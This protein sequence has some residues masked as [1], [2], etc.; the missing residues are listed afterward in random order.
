MFLCPCR[1]QVPLTLQEYLA[2]SKPRLDSQSSLADREND[3]GYEY[4]EDDD[5]PYY[6]D[7]DEMANDNNQSG[8][9]SDAGEG[10]G[11]GDPAT[12]LADP[13]TP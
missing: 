11:E 6:D 4:F 12:P 8:A 3:S 7:D 1:P 9:E 5:D 2:M 10:E 13:D